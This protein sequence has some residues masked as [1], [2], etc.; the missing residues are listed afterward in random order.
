[1]ET[2]K[3]MQ[4]KVQ[5]FWVF[6]QV[7]VCMDLPFHATIQRSSF[8]FDKGN[9]ETPSGKMQMYWLLRSSQE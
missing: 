8:E 7:Q 1:M 5:S 4:A 2:C 9:M 3:T 6:T